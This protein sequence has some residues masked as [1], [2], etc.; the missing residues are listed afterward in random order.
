MVW[1]YPHFK[2][3]QP[4][5][6]ED[7]KTQMKCFEPLPPEIEKV[8]TEVVDAT[9]KIHRALGPGLI[10]SVYEK[11]LVHELRKRQFEVRSQ[12]DLPITYDDIVIDSGLRPDL[13][14]ADLLIV[15]V[16]AVERMNPVYQAQLMTYLKLMK[17]R[18]G[19]L[20]NFNVPVIS[21]GIKRVILLNFVVPLCLG[22][23]VVHFFL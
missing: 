3:V 18:L 5:R 14:I 17:K 7:T 11:C 2:S 9:Y 12:L 22:V 23:L 8:A 10:E 15:E 13:L 19:F 20:I 16:K 1:T 21:Q 4:Q 6:P